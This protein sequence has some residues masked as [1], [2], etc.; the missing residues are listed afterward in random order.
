[1]IR[2]RPEARNTI[3]DIQ[4]NGPFE[5]SRDDITFENRERALPSASRGAYREYTVITPGESDRGAR[6]IVTSGDRNRDP[7]DY[8]VLY[9]TDDHYDSFWIVVE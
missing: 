2:C 4:R 7:A 3:R 5:F 8:Q 6:R 1:L 9:Y